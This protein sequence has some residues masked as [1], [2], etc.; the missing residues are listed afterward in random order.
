MWNDERV[1]LLNRLWDAGLSA[2]QCAA[3][4]NAETAA[5]FTRNAIISKIR[6]DPGQAEKHALSK[7]PRRKPTVVKKMAPRKVTPRGTAH[8][9]RN[10][11]AQ[12]PPPE[13]VPPAQPLPSPQDVLPKTFRVREIRDGFVAERCTY[14]DSCTETP[15]KGRFFCEAH[16]QIVYRPSAPP[17]NP[18]SHYR[19][20]PRRN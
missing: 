14:V 13:W 8:L 12:M 17:K 20:Q 2:S 6:R 16:C 9:N 19:S 11:R 4:I 3:R 10:F 15:V 18:Q 1:T 7:Q 5:K